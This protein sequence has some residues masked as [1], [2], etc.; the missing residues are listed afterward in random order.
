MCRKDSCNDD[1]EPGLIE[2]LREQ[3]WYVTGKKY[4]RWST[5]S[6]NSYDIIMCSDQRLACN[7]KWNSPAYKSHKNG[8][9][10]IE[11][12][13]SR[14]VKAGGRFKYIKNS[15]KAGYYLDP[16]TSIEIVDPFNPITLGYS[17][18]TQIFNSKDSMVAIDPSRLSSEVT[19][20]VTGSGSV[21]FN[22]GKTDRHGKYVFVG[23]FGTRYPE[24]FDSDNLNSAGLTILKRA[25]E[26]AQNPIDSSN[27][28]N[29][30]PSTTTTTTVTTTTIPQT[31]TT[32][33]SIIPTTTTTIPA[34][35]TTCD[36][37]CKQVYGMNYGKCKWWCSRREINIGRQGCSW[38]RRCCCG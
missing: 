16:R 25:I 23:W 30:E 37:I 27:P 36:E 35:L 31:T 9:P 13:D 29:S 2:W 7:V 33:T 20:L 28:D 17:G 8:K 4:N 3:G 11:I 1:L 24:S 12:T 22:V 15:K 10:F 38:W 5:T 34:E 19:N 26:W 6:L 14:I 32:T 21:L 18:S